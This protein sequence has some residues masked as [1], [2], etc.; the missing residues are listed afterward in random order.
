[1]ERTGAGGASLAATMLG[2]P[3][4]G[5]WKK[6]TKFGSAG[7]RP[8]EISGRCGGKVGENSESTFVFGSSNARY[9]PLP[10][11]RKFVCKGAVY[12]SFP[13]AHRIKNPCD[14]TITLGNRHFVRFVS[15]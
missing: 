6:P 14:G 8:K 1:M 15:V 5:V 9:S 13:D 11:R 7:S 10:A 12:R 2:V 3:G 4:V